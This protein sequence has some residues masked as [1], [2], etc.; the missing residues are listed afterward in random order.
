MIGKIE[1][2]GIRSSGFHAKSDGS[3]RTAGRERQRSLDVRDGK[4][5]G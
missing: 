1:I 5:K 4:L 3:N 2:D